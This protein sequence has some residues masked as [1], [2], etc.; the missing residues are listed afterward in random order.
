[1]GLTPS[2][3]R[4]VVSVSGVYSVTLIRYFARSVFPGDSK[5]ARAASPIHRVT[6]AAPPFLLI[7]GTRDLLG[8]ESQAKSMHRR[9]LKVG[10]T[11][12][13]ETLAG[14]GHIQT[15]RRCAEPGAVAHESLLRFM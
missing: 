7:V 9:L 6:N 8:L 1:M 11:S 14:I 12:A 15:M 10:A 5:A 13:L 3:I 2:L 4:G